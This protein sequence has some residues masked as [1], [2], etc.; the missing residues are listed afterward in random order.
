VNKAR[1]PGGRETW[2]FMDD[3][4]LGS[5]GQL[6]QIENQFSAWFDDGNENEHPLQALPSQ[7]VQ[8]PRREKRIGIDCQD[9]LPVFINRKDKTCNVRTPEHHSK[10]YLTRATKDGVKTGNAMTIPGVHRT[11]P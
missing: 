2:R 5:R 10:R 11:I 7:P 4:V 8:R 3:D 9:V 6:R 1:K